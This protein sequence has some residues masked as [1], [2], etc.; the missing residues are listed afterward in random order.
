[1]VRSLG[2]FRVWRVRLPVR[3]DGW[4][5]RVRAKDLGYTA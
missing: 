1:M 5:L 3:V 2:C 4:G